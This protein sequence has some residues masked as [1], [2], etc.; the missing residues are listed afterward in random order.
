MVILR[1]HIQGHD[2]APVLLAHAL[3]R[4]KGPRPGV[5]DEEI[6][7]PKLGQDLLHHRPHALTLGH[8]GVHE[9]SPV[10]LGLELR[11]HRGAG[12]GIDLGY[13]DRRPRLRARPDVGPAQPGATTRDD[14]DLSFERKLVQYYLNVLAGWPSSSWSPIL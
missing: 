4:A 7:L 6:D 3:G 10:A 2:L 14:A 9:Q 13:G 1:I 8:V 12:L 5:V 11:D